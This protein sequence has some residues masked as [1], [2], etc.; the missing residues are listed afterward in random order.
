MSA[1]DQDR[2]LTWAEAFADLRIQLEMLEC[3]PNAVALII[4]MPK[5]ALVSARQIVTNLATNNPKISKKIPPGLPVVVLYD[6]TTLE[7]ANAERMRE[8]GWARSRSGSSS[9]ASSR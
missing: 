3:K 2:P 6:G 1:T 8:A 4:R 7:F 9:R 5:D